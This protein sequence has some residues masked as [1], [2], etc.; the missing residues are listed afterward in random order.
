M[1][2]NS[3]K[4][5]VT[6]RAMN[7]LRAAEQG[8][9]ASATQSSA[10]LTELADK[11]QTVHLKIMRRDPGT[12]LMALFHEMDRNPRE[13]A[14]QGLDSICKHEGGAGDYE[15]HLRPPDGPE[16]IYGVIPVTGAMTLS[17]PRS[18]PPDPFAQSA[19]PGLAGLPSTTPHANE[20]QTLSA[21]QRVSDSAHQSAAQQQSQLTQMLLHQQTMAQQAA[22]AQQ[23]QMMQFMG[24]LVGGG[25]QKG[26]TQN[27]RMLREQLA[28][29][30]AK[31]AAR[32]AEARMQ[33]QLREQEMRYQALVADV[34]RTRGDGGDNKD[35]ALMTSFFNTM[36]ES[37]RAQTQQYAM[38]V[39]KM[40]TQPAAEERM[41]SLLGTVSGMA[42]SQLG[43][44]SQIAEMGIFSKTEDHP[45]RDAFLESLQGLTQMGMAVLQMKMA[46]KVK[47]GIPVMPPM[48]VQAQ[49]PAP[50]ED[51]EMPQTPQDAGSTPVESMGG[52]QQGPQAGPEVLAVIE[53]DPALKKIVALIFNGDD[54][55][56]VTAR[57][58]AHA[59][60]GN[61]IAATWLSY[62]TTFG[63]SILQ[64][65]GCE[66]PRI[67]EVSKNIIGFV[68]FVS[69][70]GNPNAWS[71]PTGYKPVR[72]RVIMSA[73]QSGPELGSRAGEPQRG[74]VYDSSLP[75]AP[76]ESIES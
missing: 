19:I 1:T 31:D 13:V 49:L 29:L 69:G 57:L 3:V 38:L 22:Q 62:P 6:Q 17:F 20:A 74:E 33:A 42:Q 64:A 18:A 47:P 71:E 50:Q 27:E 52:M 76:K 12:G 36:Q 2:R 25:D 65:F 51:Q 40:L 5:E 24:L 55:R 28:R 8:A 10:F 70:G 32:D 11:Y 35:V 48:Q 39:D 75:P 72:K 26:E 68:Q 15:V 66:P 9:V 4:R 53:K 41:A 60:S 54:L 16:K 14:A 21:Y 23:A 7:I 56:E 45:L 73:A 30:E 43:M 63:V 61:E 46:G 34:K 58:Y 59:R 37:S 67:D 44:V